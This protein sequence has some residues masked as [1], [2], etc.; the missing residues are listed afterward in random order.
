MLRRSTSIK[1]FDAFGI[2]IGVDGSWFLVLFLHD[3]RPVGAVPRHAA[4]LRRRRVHDDGG[5]RAAAV[6]LADRP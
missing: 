5:E 1:L 6:R 4:Q 3:L 2:R